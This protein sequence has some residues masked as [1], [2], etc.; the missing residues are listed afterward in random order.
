VWTKYNNSSNNNKQVTVISF[1]EKYTGSKDTNT[2][3]FLVTCN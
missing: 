1:R 2:T 3:E